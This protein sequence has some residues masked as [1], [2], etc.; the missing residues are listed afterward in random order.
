MNTKEVLVRLKISRP[1]LNKYI[2]QGLIK[3]T[4]QFNGRYVFNDD[5]IIGLSE[6]LKVIDRAQSSLIH[7]S[8]IEEPKKYDQTLDQELVKN[9]N[10]A[11]SNC[12]EVFDELEKFRILTPKAVSAKAELKNALEKI[13]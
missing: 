1:T 9:I 6:N 8:P 10:K 11:L 2:D 13:K 4:K 7:E 12:L 3:A 5:E